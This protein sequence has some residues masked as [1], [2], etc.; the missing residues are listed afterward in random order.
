MKGSEIMLLDI[1]LLFVLYVI[2]AYL[3]ICLYKKG[4]PIWVIRIFLL[5]ALGLY[6][7]FHQ[8]HINAW[9]D[10]ELWFM[11]II[12]LAHL[13]TINAYDIDDEDFKKFDEVQHQEHTRSSGSFWK[14]VTGLLFLSWIF[15]DDSS[16]DDFL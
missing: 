1:F 16:D 12:T 13:F 2:T 11:G 10:A 7:F 14:W 8:K 9:T 15:S 4:I 3:H 6:S 5:I